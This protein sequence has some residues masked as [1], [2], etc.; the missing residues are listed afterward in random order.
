MVAG[1][2]ARGTGTPKQMDTVSSLVQRASEEITCSESF[3]GHCNPKILIRH[4]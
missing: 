1:K 4:C 3:K 2:R